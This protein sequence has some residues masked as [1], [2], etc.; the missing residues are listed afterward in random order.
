MVICA[1]YYIIKAEQLDVSKLYR[2]EH[3]NHFS[4][5]FVHEYPFLK[6]A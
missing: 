2:A 5:L 6:K 1:L 3:K 4:L